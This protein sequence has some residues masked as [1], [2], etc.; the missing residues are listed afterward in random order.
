LIPFEDDSEL[1][2]YSRRGDKAGSSNTKQ[3]NGEDWP[4]DGDADAEDQLSAGRHSTVVNPMRL[5]YTANKTPEKGHKDN[6]N[7]RK[8]ETMPIW[9]E[10]VARPHGG[11]PVQSSPSPGPAFGIPPSGR[12]KRKEKEK[13]K[14][15]YIPHNSPRNL[16]AAN[17]PKGRD[18]P[19]AQLQQILA[20]SFLTSSATKSRCDDDASTFDNFN[21][22]TRCLESKNEFVRELLGL[23]HT[24]KEFVDELWEKYQRLA[25]HN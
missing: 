10:V 15:Q 21:E 13:T 6:A 17:L 22:P 14:E 16:N 20:S 23:I 11:F 4:Y 9:D 3:K 5:I 24:D 1:W 8:R 19:Q 2:P 25:I 18:M 7:R 12:R